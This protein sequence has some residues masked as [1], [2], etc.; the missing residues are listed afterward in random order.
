MPSAPLFPALNG[1]KTCTRCKKKQPVEDFYKATKSQDGYF[2]T[3]KSCKRAYKAQFYSD[4]TKK[5]GLK[6]TR[7]EYKRKTRYNFSLAESEALLKSQGYC[8]AICSIHFD[9]KSHK[10]KPFIDHCH[11]TGKV[12]GLLC[13]NCNFSLGGFKDNEDN[14]L[15]AIQYLRKNK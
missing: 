1:F 6:K 11:A 15:A 14:L 13:N 9:N 2:S 10:T 7:A 12:R 5:D 8:C 3:C 4:E